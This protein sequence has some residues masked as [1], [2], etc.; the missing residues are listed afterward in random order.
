VR[1]YLI[2]ITAAAALLLTAAPSAWAF[3]DPN[4]E[5]GNPCVADGTEPGATMIGLNSQGSLPFTQPNIPPEGK[6]VITRWKAQVGIGLGP[7]KQQLIASHQVG[8]EDDR[9]VGE[10]AV[11]TLVPGSNEFATRIPVSEYDHVGLN[12]PEGTLVCHQSMNVAGRVKGSF[13]TGE[14]R[15]FEVLVNLGVPVT[16]KVEPDRDGDG[17][18]DETQVECP[19]LAL[20]HENCRSLTVSAVPTVTKGAIVLQIKTG[21][22]TTATVSGFVKWTEALTRHRHQVTVEFARITIPVPF[23]AT[24]TATVPLPKPLLRHLAKLPRNQSVTAKLTISA[25]EEREMGGG[26]FRLSVRLPGR[27]ARSHRSHPAHRWA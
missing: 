26:S 20:A 6:W 4:E 10:S 24:A 17:Y 12:G 5:V 16:V 27:R 18:G 1:R 8:E 11:E 25:V 21:L 23:E 13:V 7:L 14:A 9:K 2:A 19:W 3:H 22:P 15:H